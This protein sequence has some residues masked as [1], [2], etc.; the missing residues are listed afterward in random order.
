[1]R[2]SKEMRTVSLRKGEKTWPTHDLNEEVLRATQADRDSFADELASVT[3]YSS[4]YYLS[5]LGAYYVY[6]HYLARVIQ[7]SFAAELGTLSGVSAF[8]LLTGMPPSSR[9][10][11]IDIEARER[12]ILDGFDADRLTVVTGSSVDAELVRELGLTAIDLLFVDT[13][14]TA[15]QA[16]AEAAMYFP[17]MRS[18]GIAAF[19]DI[20]LN[21]MDQ[22]WN[23][24]SCPKAEAGNDM[25]YTGF[26]IAGPVR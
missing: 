15:A 4:D 20:H 1:M 26:G 2:V 7:P 22:F 13:D 18:G 17:L 8:A 23:L 9:L 24:L 12:P 25:H 10:V 16:T 6:L 5:N 21:D 19:D 14:H 3:E 11:T